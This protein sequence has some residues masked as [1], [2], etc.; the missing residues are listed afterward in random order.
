MK[1]PVGL[2]IAMLLVV[3]RWRR[4]CRSAERLRFGYL[5]SEILDCRRHSNS[6]EPRA[7]GPPCDAEV[8]VMPRSMLDVK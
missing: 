4:S 8:A 7:I 2:A 6:R 1:L 5:Q 3:A